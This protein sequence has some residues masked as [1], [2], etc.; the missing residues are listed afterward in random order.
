M[1]MPPMPASPAQP[2]CLRLAVAQTR[3]VGTSAEGLALLREACLSARA[4]QADLLVIP[5][6]GLTGYAWPLAHLS[7]LAEPA[8]GPLCRAACALAREHR[9]ALVIAYPE[10][11]ADGALYNAAQLIDAEGVPRLHYR[12]THLFGSLDRDRFRA[13][14]TLPKPVVVQGFRLALAICYDIE[15]P[16]V[17]RSYRLQD[18]DVLLV[19]TAN[20]HPYTSVATT[21]VPARAEENGLYVAY[22]NYCGAEGD[23]NYCGRS[24]ICGPDGRMLAQAGGD[25]PALILAELRTDVLDQVHAAQPYLADRRPD[26]YLR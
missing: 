25:A 3:P 7:T 23:L 22:A 15:F 12:K 24:S 21:L 4:Q 8:D 17:A 19:P 14:D 18:A 5:E 16:E 2:G 13:G 9:L 20:M 6:M 11:G 10:R 26:L 1:S